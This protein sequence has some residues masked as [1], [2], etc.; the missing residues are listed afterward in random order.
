MFRQV[1]STLL[2]II[3]AVQP[4]LL[5]AQSANNPDVVDGILSAMT[6][7]SILDGLKTGDRA[8]LPVNGTLTISQED[9]DAFR[10]LN[11]GPTNA[12]AVQTNSLQKQ[13]VAKGANGG[14]TDPASWIY[15]SAETGATARSF[16]TDI[17]LQASTAASSIAKGT[18]PPG[19]AL[20]LA[21]WFSG[22]SSSPDGR[23]GVTQSCNG[24]VRCM[25]TSCYKPAGEQNA[26][27]GAA[28]GASQIVQSM[29]DGVV[30]AETGLAP[31]NNFGCTP[32]SVV[33]QRFNPDTEQMEDFRQDV[34]KETG[35]PV[36]ISCGGV[37][38]PLVGVI[39]DMPN[40]YPSC[41]LKN[42]AIP[43]NSYPENCTPRLFSGKESY[44]HS[45]LGSSVGL[46]NDCC[47]L[48]ARA[49]ANVN[50][51]PVAKAVYVQSGLSSHVNSIV[52][53]YT[54]P[55]AQY[56][57]PMWE[58]AKASVGNLI[59]TGAGAGAAT[60][61]TSMGVAV[62]SAAAMADAVAGMSSTIGGP[63]AEITNAVT[64][65][66]GEAMGQALAES[67][68]QDA[69]AQT[70]TDQMGQ[71][72]DFAN[73]AMMYYAIA[74]FIGKMLTKCDTEEITQGINIAERKCVVFGEYCSKE[75]LG[76]CTRRST[77]AC[78]YQS[79]VARIMGS[80]IKAQLN[81][82]VENGGYGSSESPNC[83]GISVS[84]LERVNWDQ[85]DLTEWL[86]TMKAGGFGAAQSEEDVDRM[87][88][89][90]AN[91]V[92]AKFA[93]SPP[94][95]TVVNRV[96]S[97]VDKFSSLTQTGLLESTRATSY[98]GEQLCYLTDNTIPTYQ[99]TPLIITAEDV[100]VPLGG[101]GVTEGSIRSCGPNCIDVI[102]GRE[103]TRYLHDSCTRTYDQFYD[104]RVKRPDLIR[105]AKIIAANWDDHM[106]IKIDSAE[107]FVSNQF[108]SSIANPVRSVCELS[109]DWHLFQNYT[110]PEAGGQNYIDVTSHF[111]VGGLVRTNT[112]VRVWGAGN[113]YATVRIEYDTAPPTTQVGPCIK[114]PE[115]T[116]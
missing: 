92:E 95:Q 31:R 64:D 102:L 5:Y 77:R 99:R 98:A 93:I 90:T 70:L 38:T 57:Q 100:I 109:T 110:P 103:G 29:R 84:D 48:G 25:G 112:S 4:P 26:D 11:G 1:V 101:S 24:P 44:C 43:T 73:T 39:G 105:S 35:N 17:G 49:G 66:A 41:T 82:G 36:V 47:D 108:Y 59:G 33:Q 18:D 15:K 61:A 2:A 74:S 69:A 104:V 63:M 67:A 53:Q 55:V 96:Q 32:T 56:F 52:G 80:Q 91:Q 116:P 27:F 19:T 51:I 89:P 71:V 115:P 21:D 62:D 113:A 65:A 40:N 83:D 79:M 9:L 30:C 81:P 60:G 68:A 86:D 46:A 37:D 34:C 6:F 20:R 106:R 72:M 16:G 12:Q 13:Q 94:G 42:A 107:V 3:L 50:Y 23:G 22:C 75:A 7:K 10:N 87:M 78:C 97:Q 58:T 88:S 114:P 111:K 76:A 54:A 28:T 85:I 8:N 14:G 45:W